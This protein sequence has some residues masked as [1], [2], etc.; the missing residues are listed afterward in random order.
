M[1]VRPFFSE[2]LH[3]LL[4]DQVSLSSERVELFVQPVNADKNFVFTNMVSSGVLPESVSFTIK[5]FPEV[6]L[7]QDSKFV[8]LGEHQVWT[9][10]Y[11][12]LLVNSKIYFRGPLW[13]FAHQFAVLKGFEH[14]LA[15][16]DEERK[17]LKTSRTLAYDIAID[18]SDSFVGVVSSY[19][20]DPSVQIFVGFEGIFERAV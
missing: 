7:F 4:Y 1:P 16:T 12:E 14:Y 10:S 20:A 15:M 19:F 18:P 9:A 13:L 11:F 8:P 3:Y 17:A 6:M 2:V 5:A